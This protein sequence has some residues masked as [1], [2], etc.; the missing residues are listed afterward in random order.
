MEFTVP[1]YRGNVQ[2]YLQGKGALQLV[3]KSD[4]DCYMYFVGSVESSIKIK[5]F[6]REPIEA[7][8]TI[9]ESGS[10][11]NFANVFNQPAE[12]EI[13]ECERNIE[14]KMH[15]TT[16]DESLPILWIGVIHDREMPVHKIEWEALRP[17]QEDLTAFATL[18]YD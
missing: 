18:V 12:I 2:V 16:R 11:D 8:Q 6:R 9:V 1:I 13:T 4:S 17:I 7:A 14:I 10:D 3:D 15:S 5:D